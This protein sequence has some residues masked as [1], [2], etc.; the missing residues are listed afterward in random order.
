MK[1]EEHTYYT[2]IIAALFALGIMCQPAGLRAALNVR[3]AQVLC[4]SM[5]CVVEKSSPTKCSPKTSNIQR[6][7]RS[8]QI[9]AQTSRKAVTRIAQTCSAISKPN[10]SEE[11]VGHVD[12]EL[13]GLAENN[14]HYRSLFL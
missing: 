1:W 3:V 9:P 10:D 12:S 6:E 2:K 4:A 5:S 14:I 7:I 13:C 8:S 11:S